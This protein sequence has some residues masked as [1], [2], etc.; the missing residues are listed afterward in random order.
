[1]MTTAMMKNTKRLFIGITLLFATFSFGQEAEYGEISKEELLEASYPLDS[2]ANAAVLFEQR[3]IYYDYDPEKGFILKTEVHKRI[4]LYNKEGFEQATEEVLLFQTNGRAEKISG[5]EGSTYSLVGG[6]IVTTNLKK[7]GIFKTEISDYV[8]KTS[9]TMPALTEG[10]VVEYRYKI[11]SPYSQ[12][13]ERIMLQYE[14]PIKKIKIA[15]AIPEYYTFRKRTVGFLPIN[16]KES[17]DRQ[18][19]F[20]YGNRIDYKITK[21]DINANMVPAFKIEPYSGNYQNYISAVSFELQSTQF[22]YS[23]ITNYAS[24]W[25]GIARGAFKNSKFGGAMTT[26][27]YFKKDIDALISGVSNPMEKMTL[28]YDYVKEKMTWNEVSVIMPGKNMKK[29]YEE[30]VG[31]SAEI[32]LMLIAMLKYAKVNVKPILVTTGERPLSLFPTVQGLDYVVARVRIN[33][34]EYILDA[35]DE[36][37]QPNVLPDRVVH[38]LGRLISERG[39]SEMMF[40]RPKKL[41]QMQHL[42]SC[43]MDKEGNVTGN[44]RARYTFYGAHDFRV[45]NGTKKEQENIDRLKE[46][47]GLENITEYKVDN[48]DNLG[49]PILESFAFETS[50]EVEVI[51]DEMFFSPMLFL[52]GK[53]NIFKSEERK[54]PIDLRYGFSNNYSVTIKIPEGY[55]VAE[56]PEDVGFKLPENMGSFV[57]RS[58]IS[59]N[60]IQ[61]SVNETF[62]T[63]LITEQYY[64]ALKTFYGKLVEKQSDQI[65]LKKI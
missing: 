41:S 55:T 54:Y 33:D 13:I 31:N 27:K 25:G 17:T 1:M 34:N 2:S 40:F 51:E 8:K 22:P 23:T 42:V 29:V 11:A 36:Y 32:N 52:R 59:G 56:K 12:S 49:Q 26:N 62:S 15:L 21:Y 53:E 35:T 30:R 10:S 18:N 5:L 16:L 57:F 44:R 65:V 14:I 37:G 24:T 45:E 39:D 38:G 4:K 46:H 50:D 60:M 61:L 6:E 9:F 28:I 3:K 19:D 48:M 64:M 63:P 47:Y 7:D 20:I 58:N 43:E